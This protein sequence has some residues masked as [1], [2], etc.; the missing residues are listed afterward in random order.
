MG[1]AINNTQLVGNGTPGV[2][3]IKT[4]LECVS[5]VAYD[6]HTSGTLAPAVANS[7]GSGNYETALAVLVQATS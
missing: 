4:G 6:T 7:N 5:L 3:Y 1:T 2:A